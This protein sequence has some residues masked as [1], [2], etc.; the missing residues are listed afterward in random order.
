MAND[1]Q[2]LTNQLLFF[3]DAKGEGSTNK[4]SLFAWNSTLNDEDRKVFGQ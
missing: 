3:F 4:D 2:I 1:K